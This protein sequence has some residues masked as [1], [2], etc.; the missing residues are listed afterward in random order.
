MLW[1]YPYTVSASF[2]MASCLHCSLSNDLYGAIILPVSASTFYK[3][4]QH[5]LSAQLLLIYSACWFVFP[6]LG[7]YKPGRSADEVIGFHLMTQSRASISPC[8]FFTYWIIFQEEKRSV[9]H[10]PSEQSIL[11]VAVH[12]CSSSHVQLVSAGVQVGVSAML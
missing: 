9:C 1:K 5:F 3:R 7:Y 4:P 10:R 6:Q 2:C 12:Y 8:V 11:Q